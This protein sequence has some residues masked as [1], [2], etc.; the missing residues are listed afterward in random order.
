[1]NSSSKL[2]VLQ[3]VHYFVPKHQAGTELYTYYLSKELQ[4]LGH[5][6][7]I[8]TF[9]DGYPY[10]ES[11]MEKTKYNGIPLITLFKQQRTF[12]KKQLKKYPVQS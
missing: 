11:V 3:V 8:L 12:R 4:N 7:T 9:E 10:V 1:M 5:D 2:K 6:V